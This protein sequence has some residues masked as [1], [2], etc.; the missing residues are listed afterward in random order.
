M[1]SSYEAPTICSRL[2]TDKEQHKHPASLPLIP[3]QVPTNCKELEPLDTT[4]EGFEKYLDP[5]L[6]TS[7]LHHR[8]YTS[9]ELT[10]MSNSKDI[11]TYYTYADIP[12]VRVPRPKVNE[13]GLPLSRPKS[14]YDREK[15]NE[16]FR[17]IRTHNKLR[18]VPG[19]FRTESRD[20]YVKPTAHP[21]SQIHNYEEEVRSAYQRA[22]GQLS[23]NI[24][25]EDKIMV[26]NYCTEYS[27]TASGKPT[28]AVFD[29][30][31]RKNR[32]L[33]GTRNK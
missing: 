26:Q 33:I 28:C 29:P 9:H 1:R 30:F 31:V 24:P 21:T 10:K 16:D 13:W 18:W 27:T 6:T 20:N 22:A 4:Y 7:R 25:Q 32:R 11:M 19:T 12:W 3:P 2:V 15:F 5:Y 17:E 8:P 23:T 14:M